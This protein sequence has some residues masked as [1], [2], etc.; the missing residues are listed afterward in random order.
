MDEHAHHRPA[1]ALA[2]V[3]A[4]CGFF[5]YHPGFLQHQPQPIVRDFHSMLLADVFIKMPQRK[6]RIDV[7]F[8]P[9]EQFDSA[10]LYPLAARSPAALVHHGIHS[11][12]L[13]PPAN[14]SHL[15]RL[16]PNNLGR[17]NP[18]QLLGQWL[19]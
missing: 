16:D 19:W 8:K 1:L 3:L 13:H 17:L 6:I 10:G 11:V 15:A 4:A 12:M 14:S 5:R 7:A 2:S 18:A 9:A